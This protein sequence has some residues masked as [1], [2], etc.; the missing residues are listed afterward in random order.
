MTPTTETPLLTGAVWAPD[1]ALVLSDRSQLE[2]LRRKRMSISVASTLEQC[3]AS[4]VKRLLPQKAD[5]FGARELGIESHEIL[6]VFYQLPKASRTQ[7]AMYQAVENRANTVWDADAVAQRIDREALY[8]DKLTADADYDVPARIIRDRARWIETVY[9]GLL[10]VFSLETPADVEVEATER[11]IFTS[12]EGVPIT[13]T[14]DRILRRPDGTV[15]VDD[16][17]FASESKL[18]PR[19]DARDEYADQGRVYAKAIEQE[20]GDKV[21]QMRLIFPALVGKTVNSETARSYRDV[22]LAEAETEASTAFLVESWD[23]MNTMVDQG[24]FPAKP[25][26]LCGWCPLVNSCPSAVLI[27]KKA[28]ANAPTQWSAAQL[29]IP[30]DEEPTLPAEPAA[31]EPE[32]EQPV[33]QHEDPRMEVATLTPV[34]RNGEIMSMPASN[35][36]PLRRAVPSAAPYLEHI[37]PANPGADEITNLGSYAV[38]SAFSLTGLALRHMHA[39]GAPIS[40]QS[41]AALAETF[42]MIVADV[43]YELVSTTSMQ[44][45]LNPRL[46]GVLAGVLDVSPFPMGRSVEEIER[47]VIATKTALWVTARHATDLHARQD[48]VRHSNAYTTLAAV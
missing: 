24:Q 37:A 13:V 3:P 17:K 7:A 19:D 34:G 28:Q 23:A 26:V 35:V 44:H 8:T 36:T 47:W 21:S 38:Q 2:K 18:N 9:G 48:S 20:L 27:G 1:G 43:Q 10:G 46:R 42:A 31:Q 15:I 14:V 25:S 11:R 29:G 41:H 5:P 4:F 33:E 6:D 40:E 32:P 30:R 39:L 16:W 45:G 12:V 22:P